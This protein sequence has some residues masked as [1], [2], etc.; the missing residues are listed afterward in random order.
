[1]YSARPS[2]FNISL[3]YAAV[4]AG[5]ILVSDSL[6]GWFLQ[7]PGQI[8]LASTLK[9]YFFVLC[10]SMLLYGLL[11]WRWG[12]EPASSRRQG[13]NSLLYSLPILLLTL[14]ASL[15]T[16][17]EKEASEG[18]RLQDM[19]QVRLQM[20]DAWLAERQ[21]DA[22]IMFRDPFLSDAYQR[23]R[24]KGELAG[25]DYLFS[26]LA[27]YARQGIFEVCV[28]FDEDGQMLWQSKPLDGSL[29]KDFRK[30]LLAAA[31]R[32]SIT[33]LRSYRETS[34]QIR[35]DFLCP[36]QPKAL[37]GTRGPIVLLRG[38]PARHLPA[39]LFAWSGTRSGEMVLF[40]RDG[41]DI[42]Y[43]HPFGVSK[44]QRLPL[45]RPHLLASR[46]AAGEV[47]K[48]LKA[49]DYAGRPV[50]GV[51]CE[52]PGTGWF[53]IA[54]LE[55]SEIYA[56]VAGD[57]A[58]I[59]LAGLL[60]L[61]S[62][63]TA[64]RL[65]TQR[66]Q[67]A[68]AAATHQAQEEQMRATRLLASIAD[69][70]SDAIFAKDLRGRYL[71]FSRAALQLADK[72]EQEVLGQDDRAIFPEN[73]DQLWSNDQKV[74]AENA[75]FTFQEE[76]G[77]STFQVAKGPI[78]DEAGQVIGIYGV[79][80]DITRRLQAEQELLESEMRYRILADNM[81]DVIWLYDLQEQRFTYVTPSMQTLTGFSRE[82]M[83]QMPMR[84][85]LTEESFEHMSALLA[86]ALAGV[87]GGDESLRKSTLELEIVTRSGK[88]VP[89][90]TAASLVSDQEGRITHMQGVTRDI[91]QRKRMESQLHEREE[92]LS[93]LARRAVAMLTLPEVAEKMPEDLFLQHGLKIAKELTASQDACAQFLPLDAEKDA[94]A[95]GDFQ[96]GLAAIWADEQ[97]QRQ[98]LIL[99]EGSQPSIERL[100]TVP[101]MESGKVVLLAA[102]G[103]KLEEYQT[104]DAET[105]Q[106]IANELW[107][108]VQR[109]RAQSEL[110][111]LSQALEQCP[112][113]IVITNLT[114]QIEYVNEA[115][116]QISGYSRSE[117]L[118]KNPR[119][120]QSGSTP[121]QTFV[122]MWSELTRGQPWKGQLT[123]RRKDGS[124]YDEF[125]HIAPI[126]QADGS[127]THYLAVKQDITEKKRLGEEL[128]RHR[129]H[130]E[131]LVKMR[132]A[133]L[134][135]ARAR[136]ESAN[137]AKSAF[138]ANMSHE[139]RTP[140]NA[141]L[142][143]TYLLQLDQVTSAQAQRLTKI[144]N[145]AHHLLAII[146]DI[147]DVSKI[148]ASKLVL[149]EA[150]FFL[151]EVVEGTCA[152][153]RDS[154]ADKGLTL[155][156]ELG[157]VPPWLRGDATRLRQ[158]LLN[159]V[160]NAV[161]FTE[162]GGL[163]V[164]AKL[165]EES[166]G[167][168]LVKFEVEDS[169]IGIAAE[170]LEGL[171]R[172]FQQADATTTR[173]YGG[174]GL[175]L[176]ITGH[177][178]RLMGGEAGAESQPGQG[179]RFWF[180]V[181]LARGQGEVPASPAPWPQTPAHPLP[182]VHSPVA[183]GGRQPHQSRGC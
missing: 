120:L 103:N 20:L 128:D 70:S 112:D 146:N 151:E 15:Y 124:V 172:N 179:S 150:D 141:I 45:S 183:A 129:H 80:R 144:D 169:G 67:L 88:I 13:P 180:T 100:I 104:R 54:K 147:L 109:R 133:E 155:A 52:V 118:G 74:L 143:L 36:L 56:L 134:E 168:L 48:P 113:S 55:R 122:E 85:T 73:A 114:A 171:F 91:S 92:T 117:L 28:L 77:S 119:V 10:T 145:A 39:G 159:Y 75:S 2:P 95:K 98:T 79:S 173:K 68:I 170:E 40:Q 132:T 53:L 83:L 154:A 121:K 8:T 99:N 59:A 24:Q 37:P 166:Q 35:L 149:E 61:L 131:D 47:N 22:E 17:H 58:W 12:E 26:H 152:L 107:R 90:E 161:K 106:M 148:E 111:K 63:G 157:G 115:F 123:N 38:Y 34:G 87:S 29:D 94:P 57:L 182:K 84:Q 177:L 1:M 110:A 4:A 62:A 32:K 162:R 142:G 60:G 69:S 97:R 25:R 82:E 43:L 165:L 156:V 9:G 27:V 160:S 158:A 21:V 137:R 18:A 33:R 76:L 66:Q 64:A 23:W 51:G 136:A 42:V 108:I 130:L 16:L 46:V 175:G 44:N 116:V 3:I 93:L 7:T 11:R 81:V 72:T 181:R 50:L 139:I 164:R 127:V 126:R 102:L 178:A 140:M 167:R 176:A 135:E 96:I 101:V 19:V 30:S 163:T 89:V 49:L 174:T 125:A 78:H 14:T 86:Q 153:V 105:L 65:N 138:L 41:Q 5:W 71:L 6:V 31:G